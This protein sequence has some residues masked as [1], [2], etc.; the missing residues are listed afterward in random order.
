MIGELSLA[1][2]KHGYEYNK[3]LC[4]YLEENASFIRTYFEKNV[5]ELKLVNGD[6]S[7]VTF[8]NCASIYDKV[9]AKAES[10]KE[11]YKGGE[12]GGILS[13]FFGVE[14]AVAMNDGTWFGDDYYNFVRFNYGTS[15][16][17]VKE[18]VE[19]I[20]KAVKALR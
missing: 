19:N 2:Y 20:A 1:A 8:I 17:R 3:E 18:A 9:K 12:G 4:K 11:R 6:A 7:F 16:E 10:N 5:P 13:R 15:R 14:A